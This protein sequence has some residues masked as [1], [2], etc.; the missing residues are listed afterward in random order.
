MKKKTDSLMIINFQKFAEPVPGSNISE[1]E[2][3]KTGEWD[4]PAYG[5]MVITSEML[6]QFIK[7][8]QEEIRKGICITEGHPVGDEELPAVGWFKELKKEGEDSLKA[9]VEWTSRGLSLLADKAYKFFSPEFYFTFEDPETRKVLHNVLTGGALTNKPYF[10][11]L[12]AV[13]L[14]ENILISKKNNSMKL[15]EILAKEA[16]DVTAEEKQFMESMIK[17]LDA[18]TI[19]KYS[20]AEKKE[21]EDPE[22]K[23]MCNKMSDSEKEDFK[24]MT[25]E[26]KKKFIADKK[27]AEKKKA[28][29]DAAKA[30]EEKIAAEKAAN[31]AAEEE[32]KKMSEAQLGEK[33]TLA[34]KELIQAK[35]EIKKFEMKE[36]SMIIDGS[37]EKVVC[38]ES[39]K[40][41]SFLP[42]S[43]DAIKEFAETLSTDQCKKFFEILGEAKKAQVFGE[44]GSGEDGLGDIAGKGKDGT[45]I[46]SESAMLAEEAKKIQTSEKVSL[47]QATIMAAERLGK[48]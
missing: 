6:D 24:K 34:E 29:E 23:E 36:R 28:S 25:P 11:S 17:D 31:E 40:K 4:H 43:K 12:E 46:D 10:K 8:F 16:A 48:K 1:I 37:I 44:L 22:E 39:N 38:S 5:K 2:I 33:L 32:K 35:E 15:Q 27:A 26:E 18:E 20:L 3:L 45:P 9:V 19:K 42:K 41:G 21:E 47:E 14:S 30:E 7:H 13:V